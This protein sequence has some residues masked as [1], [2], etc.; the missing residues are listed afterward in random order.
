MK[1]PIYLELVLTLKA[2]QVVATVY[3]QLCYFHFL[4]IFLLTDLEIEIFK[5]SKWSG[6]VFQS[7]STIESSQ[8]LNENI[9]DASRRSKWLT[10]EMENMCDSSSSSFN[11]T[12]MLLHGLSSPQPNCTSILDRFKEI[13]PKKGKKTTLKHWQVVGI[14]IEMPYQQRVFDDAYSGIF[15]PLTF[16]PLSR[17]IIHNM[18]VR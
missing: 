2:G 14:V 3:R 4:I 9:K 18:L 15:F 16:L 7:S 5:Y 17:C 13:N 1:T 8:V 10:I 11:F 12:S 6:V